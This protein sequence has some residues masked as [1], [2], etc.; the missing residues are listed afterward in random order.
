MSCSNNVCVNIDG[1]IDGNVTVEGIN[2]GS[3]KVN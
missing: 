3:I 1:E 2:D